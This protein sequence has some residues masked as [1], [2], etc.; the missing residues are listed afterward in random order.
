MST[1]TSGAVR[2]VI[3]AL[4]WLALADG[5]RATLAVGAVAVPVAL[6]VSLT[7]SPPAA[8]R[9]RVWPTVRFVPWFA[10][11]ALAASA[12]VARRA[13]RPTMGLAPA[14]VPVATR[15]TSARAR[16]ALAGLVSL[17][18]GTLAVD[19]RDRALILHLLDGR[20]RARTLDELRTVEAH[21][22]AMFGE[23][24]ERA[25]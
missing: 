17:V 23:T 6:V 24:E 12:D 14:R 11:I 4:L 22:A 25:A 16:L 19:V 21:V 13:L 5:D 8:P 20:A 3:L 10:W 1:L 7:L 2:F 9:L 15:L 18:P